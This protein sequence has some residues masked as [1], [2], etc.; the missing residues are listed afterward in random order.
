[1]EHPNILITAALLAAASGAWAD[2]IRD[3]SAD[4]QVTEPT[5]RIIRD[6]CSRCHEVDGGLNGSPRP[7]APPFRTVARDHPDYVEGVLLR[8]PRAMWSVIIDPKDAAEVRAYFAHLKALE[9]QS[10]GPGAGAPP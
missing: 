9:Q 5:P 3:R 2:S 8:P 10:A 1:M 7:D 4:P 6:I